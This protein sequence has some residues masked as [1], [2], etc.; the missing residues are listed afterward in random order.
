MSLHNKNIVFCFPLSDIVSFEEK[1]L[2]KGILYEV[3]LRFIAILSTFTATFHFN[4]NL[5][6]Q[7]KIILKHTMTYTLDKVNAC[8][9]DINNINGYGDDRYL[10]CCV[11]ES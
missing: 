9:T 8:R 11:Y 10:G 7:F 1:A 2:Y 6:G 3:F 4:R 5:N